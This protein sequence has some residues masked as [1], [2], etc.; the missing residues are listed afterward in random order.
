MQSKWGG[1]PRISRFAKVQRDWVAFYKDPDDDKLLNLLFPLC[2]LREWI[3]PAGHEVYEGE[4][5]ATLTPAARLHHELHHN[6]A[7]RLV[8]ALC[9]NAKHYNDEIGERTSVVKGFRVGVNRVGDSLDHTNYMIGHKPLRDA[10]EEVYG[11][12]YRYFNSAE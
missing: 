12:Y 11:I 10:A 9:N 4:D 3:W 8:R 6:P 2:H 5:P 1:C 7:Y